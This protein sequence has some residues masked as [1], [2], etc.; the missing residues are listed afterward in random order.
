MKVFNNLEQ[1]RHQLKQEIE[2]VCR[3]IN[4]FLFDI[5]VNRDK[6]QLIVK[7]IADTE[8]GITLGQ[9]QQLSEE[10]SD[11]I[12]RRNLITQAYRLEVSSP[13]I[14]KP[15]QFPYEYRRNIGRNL[16]VVL[17]QQGVRKEIKGELTDFNEDIIKLKTGDQIIMIPVQDIQRATIK[18][19]W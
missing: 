18:L 13:G 9:C 14:D 19:K 4:I 15:L 16:L 11:L 3:K 12:Y 7:I 2:P 5:M 10:V 8:A 17:E 6:Q 1:L